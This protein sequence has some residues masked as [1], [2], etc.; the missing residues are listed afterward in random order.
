M[1]A[2][3]FVTSWFGSNRRCK[4]RRTPSR[5]AGRYDRL[6]EME[7]LEDRSMLAAVTL[8]Q[9]LANPGASPTANDYFS[10]YSPL[11]YNGGPTSTYGSIAV[12]RGVVAIGAAGDDGLSTNAGAVWVYQ[13]ETQVPLRLQNPV[14]SYS[15]DDLFGYS[16][17]VAGRKVYIGAMGDTRYVPTGGGQTTIYNNA[18]SV[19]I[20]D[21]DT[22]GMTKLEHPAPVTDGRFGKSLAATDEILIVAAD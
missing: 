17:A 11:N 14:S 1:A 15:A 2:S 13:G 6:S 12:D 4:A 16:V 10:G 8:S 7:R 5:R 22:G 20:Y 9:V 19:H 3:R 21:L 18:G